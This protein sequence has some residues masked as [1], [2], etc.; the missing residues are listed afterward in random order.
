MVLVMLIFKN[1]K[2]KELIEKTEKLLN[3]DESVGEYP[4]TAKM[5]KGFAKDMWSSAKYAGRGLP[6]LV[7]PT[8]AAER[9]SICEQCPN[10]TDAGRCTECGCFMKKK[11]NLAASS[12]PIGKWD[13]VE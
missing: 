5:L 6:V 9:Y 2:D 1:E 8:S 11:V 13:S 3:V 12:C 10:L 4:S 7:S